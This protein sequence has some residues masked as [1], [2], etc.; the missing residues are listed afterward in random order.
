[1]QSATPYI[2]RWQASAIFDSLR[3]PDGKHQQSSTP[4]TPRRQAQSS[5]PYKPRW[6]DQQSLTSYMEHSLLAACHFRPAPQFSTITSHRS[7]PWKIA[8]I[9]QIP[10]NTKPL[11]SWRATWQAKF[12]LLTT[13]TH[14]QVHTIHRIQ[15]CKHTL[16]HA[17]ITH[18][19]TQVRAHI[20]TRTHTH[21]H[22][23]HKHTHTHTHLHRTCTE[24]SLPADAVSGLGGRPTKAPGHISA[25]PD[26]S[27][28]HARPGWC[29][30]AESRPS[31]QTWSKRMLAGF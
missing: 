23:H 31:H 5:T 13:N 4:Y 26:V 16:P 24:H 18:A 30:L 28:Q 3:N 29:L 17:H 14:T 12:S 8:K 10:M 6:Q 20:Y 27:D 7:T 25:P 11:T 15:A 2:S 19:L 1:L 21:T 9:Y 22:T